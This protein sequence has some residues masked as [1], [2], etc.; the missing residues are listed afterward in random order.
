MTEIM[1]DSPDNISTDTLAETESYVA[2][3]SL[4][5]DGET[6]WHIDVSNVT[7]HFF[8]EEWNEFVELMREVVVK[9]MPPTKMK[10]PGSKYADN[11]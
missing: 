1:P 5:P 4:E 7:L 9:S 3:K 10:K 11:A 2:W 6:T 8:E